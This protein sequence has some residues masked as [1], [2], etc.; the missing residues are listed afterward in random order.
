MRR[1]VRGFL[2]TPTAITA[3][4]KDVA[5]P[6]IGYRRRGDNVQKRVDNF[7]HVRFARP[8]ERPG[9][10]NKPLDYFPFFI[11]QVIPNAHIACGGPVHIVHCRLKH[12]N[13][14][15]ADPTQPFLSQALKAR[16][17]PV[18]SVR[19]GF[20]AKPPPC[21]SRTLR[22]GAIRGGRGV[23]SVRRMEVRQRNSARANS[24]RM[25]ENAGLPP[26]S[27][28]AS[29][30]ADS[31]KPSWTSSRSASVVQSSATG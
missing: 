20:R 8:T 11:G 21:F 24:L 16:R 19:P 10:G 17:D 2:A 27:K 18:F 14:T 13:G 23:G 4:G 15:A 9:L 22:R 3:L 26:S 30:S 29:H 6:R 5:R 1:L 7:T 12:N 28:A 31:S 25:G